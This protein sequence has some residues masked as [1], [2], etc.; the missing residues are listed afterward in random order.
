MRFLVLSLVVLA[1]AL[2]VCSQADKFSYIESKHFEI[3]QKNKGL[4]QYTELLQT[5]FIYI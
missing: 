3:L 4:S 5:F 1:S 2:F